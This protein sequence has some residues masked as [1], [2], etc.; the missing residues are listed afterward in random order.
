MENAEIKEEVYKCSKCGLCRSICPVFKTFKNEMY[1]PRGRYNIL[2]NAFASENS[3]SKKFIKDLDF[4]LNCNECK[5]FCP[6]SIDS[7]EIFTRLKS[8]YKIQA[9]PFSVKYKFILLMHNIKRHFIKNQLYNVKIKRKI[10]KTSGSKA[11]IAYFEG[12]FNKYINPSDKNAAL[13][14][15]EENGFKIIKVLDCCCGLPFLSDGSFK[16]FEKNAEKILKSAPKEAEYIVCSCS[17][18]CN[19]LKKALKDNRII[20]L[21]ELINPEQAAGSVI[22]HKNTKDICSLTGNYFLL[23]YPDFAEKMF[24]TVFY[25]KEDIEGKTILTSCNLDKYGLIEGCRIKNINAE[26]LSSA[27]Y[28]QKLCS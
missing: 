22:I 11:S 17:S 13:N 25:K 3:L 28:L 24:D 12:C 19:T 10:S 21:Y 27:E 14:L 2:N 1:L 4:C 26:I 16:Q 23:K 9:V 5:N 7:A 18:C 8:L 20:S 6:S 15:L